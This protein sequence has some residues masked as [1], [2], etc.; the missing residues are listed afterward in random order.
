M[1]DRGHKCPVDRDAK[2]ALRGLGGQERESVRYVG[3]PR[4]LAGLISDV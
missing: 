3:T 2:A 1:C 4:G